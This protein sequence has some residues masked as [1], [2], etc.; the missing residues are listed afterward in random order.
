M[1]SN[2]SYISLMTKPIP[3][4]NTGKRVKSFMVTDVVM[5]AS[6]AVLKGDVVI[7]P[8]DLVHY[9][10]VSVAKDGTAKF[11][12]TG[13][14]MTKTVKSVVGFGNM[15]HA[16]FTAMMNAEAAAVITARKDMYTALV[17][18]GQKAA[19]P[20]INHEAIIVADAIAAR[21]KAEAEAAAEASRIQKLQEAADLKAALDKE[22]ADKKAADDAAFA[23]LQADEVAVEV[24][25]SG[26][27]KTAKELVAVA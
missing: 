19:V 15:V 8:E 12:A 22:A 23:K 18:A 1:E 24:K 3:Q 2:N 14:L 26:G 27:K 25:K 5:W 20:I 4:V 9:D 21:A 7:P 17:A 11:S 6:A 13:K 16:N 10:R